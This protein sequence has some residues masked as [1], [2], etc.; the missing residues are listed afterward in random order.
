[1]L[2]LIAI[3]TT[4]ASAMPAL[5]PRPAHMELRPGQFELKPST[6][7][8]VTRETRVLGDRLAADLRPSTHFAFDVSTRGGKDAIALRLDPKLGSLGP[9]GYVFDSRPDGIEIKAFASAGLF[10]GIQTLRQLLPAQNY[11][12]SNYADV[13]WSVPCLHIEDKPRFGWRGG[14][15]DVSRHFMPKEAVLKFIDMLALHKMNS[16]HFHLTDDQGWRI[17]IKKYPKLTEVGA[18]HK[19]S[20]LTNDPT[21]VPNVP[22]GGY[23]TQEDLREIVAYA[24]DR[25]INV[26]PEI[27]MPGHASAAIASY[28]TLGANGKPIPVPPVNG[29]TPDVLSVDDSTIAFF[30]DVLTE[31]M[32][33]FPSKFIHVG[34]DEVDKGP[35]KRS[36]SAQARMKALGLKN[37]E[38]LQ[39]WFIRQMDTFLTKKGRRLIGW[40][41]ILEGGLAEGATVMSW[42]GIQGGIAAAK[43][44]HDV[45]MAPTTYTYLDYYQSQDRSREPRSIGGNLP[46]EKVFSFDPIPKELTPEEAK[47][48]LG[49]QGQLWAEYIPNIKHLEYMAF[50]RLCAIAEITWSP[51]EGKSYAD[52]VGR[53]KTHF[54]RL[55]VLDISF[56]PLDPPAPPPVARWKT[57]D[58]TE[59]FTPRTW[60]VTSAVKGAGTYKAIFDYTDGECR[61]DIGW[62]EL[63]VGD[64]VVARD[65]HFGR[66]GGE[67]VN[68]VYRLKLD[69]VEPNAKYTL[70][71]NV[72]T[73]GGTDSNGEIRLLLDSK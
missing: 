47:H 7:I 25:F 22:D 56:R 59:T 39:S 15:M 71:A 12:R 24:R 42:R 46:L 73:D 26:V 2:P 34:G 30:Q 4:Q 43:A 3:A 58:M 21:T 35:W 67:V 38:E 53:L 62:V 63:L 1:M 17:E 10:Y 11:R 23:Y 19:P 54:D 31:V 55:N 57:G 41:E 61:L 66:S 16:F 70:R 50:P 32:E 60:D 28:P 13:K 45:V 27:E 18:W 52:F 37:E 33:I 44:R 5:V 8:A 72:R 65:E 36:A 69:K 40:D 6:R 20:E 29:P 64:K 68:N 51:A 49:A 14:M 9:E 48:V